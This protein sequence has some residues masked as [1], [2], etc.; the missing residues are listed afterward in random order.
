MPMRSLTCCRRSV[1]MGSTSSPTRSAPASRSALPITG[2]GRIGRAVFTGTSV[3]H[4]ASPEERAR[5]VEARARMIERGGYGLGGRA[6]ALLGSAATADTLALVQQTLRATNPA[7]FMQAAR[8]I[9][10]AEMPPLAARLMMPL[11]MVHGEEDRVAP[12]ATNA[13][14]FA[15][16]LPHPRLIM[17]AGCGHPTRGGVPVVRQ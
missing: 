8:F 5:S 15:A 12:A 16:A 7:G 11:L 6:A 17:L 1:S 3:P 4:D 9:A 14:L 13:E 10:E 2:P